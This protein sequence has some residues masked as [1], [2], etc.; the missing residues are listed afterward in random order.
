MNIS[1]FL[2]NTTQPVLFT[3]GV[4]DEVILETAWKKLNPEAPRPFCIHNAFDRRF[5]YNLF[6]RDELKVNHRRR[7]MFALFDF[8]DAYDDWNGLKGTVDPDCN[9]FDGLRKQLRHDSHFAML[10][11]VP[12]V[13]H[14]KCQVLNE[15]DQPWGKGNESHLAIELLFYKE[16]LLGEWF[17]QKRISG[18]GELIEFTGNKV[19]FADEYIS[20]LESG[21]FEILRPIFD[22]IIANI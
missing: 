11:P 14:I 5:L 3:E 18:G 21:D 16:A 13:E 7:K 10:L 2:K 19:R 17:T 6:A 9:P 22:Y 1:T 8:D 4:S 12:N 20:T 15:D